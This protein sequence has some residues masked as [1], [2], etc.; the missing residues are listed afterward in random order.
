MTTPQSLKVLA[1]TATVYGGLSVL[2]ALQMIALLSRDAK[3]SKGSTSFAIA[4]LVSFGLLQIIA[5]VG[6]LRGKR[7]GA[8]VLL[9]ACRANARQTREP[10]GRFMA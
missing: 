2:G 4:F 5:G 6:I 7:W 9:G 3:P 8:F 10:I 1:W